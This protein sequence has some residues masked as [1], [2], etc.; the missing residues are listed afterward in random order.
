MNSYILIVMVAQLVFVAYRWRDR[1]RPVPF[2]LGSSAALG[3]W[4]V[5]LSMPIETHAVVLDMPR[6]AEG[7]AARFS[8]LGPVAAAVLASLL[9][10]GINQLIL[11]GVRAIVNRIWPLAGSNNVR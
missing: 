3:A 10:I 2:V 6:G 11:L 9:F 7:A 5:V 1:T 4:A 8:A